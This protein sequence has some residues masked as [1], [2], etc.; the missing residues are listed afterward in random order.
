MMHFGSPDNWVDFIESQVPQ[1]LEL[2]VGTW[3]AMPPPAGDELED[4]VSESLCR[5]LRQSRNRCDLPFRIDTQLVEL[6]PAAG[7]DQGR[8]DIVFSPPVPREDIYFCLEC[9]RLNVRDHSG[10]TPR[11]YFVEYVQ[12]GMLR[13]VRGQYANSVRFGGM[14]AFVLNGDVPTA[15]SGVEDNIRRMYLD[16]AMNAPG[17]FHASTLRPADLRIRE[18]QHTRTGQAVSFTLHHMFMPGDPSSPLRSIP[19]KYPAKIKSKRK[20]KTRKVPQ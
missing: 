4:T 13:F 14:L 16:L 8:M 2:V 7:Q 5:A 1:I 9:K 20:L 6:D 10:G 19:P 12:F 15:I 18:T 11:P 3:E 17:S